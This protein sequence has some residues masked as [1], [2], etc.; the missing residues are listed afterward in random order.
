M[1]MLDRLTEVFTA[2]QRLATTEVELSRAN[3]TVDFMQE[4][5][6]DL[7]RSLDDRGWQAITTGQQ[8]EFSPAGHQ[9]MVEICRTMTV[10]NPLVK[11]GV[12]LRTGYVWGKGVE[13]SAR[14]DDVNQLLQQFIEDN[15]A[16]LFDSQAH[17][18]NEK[19][20]ATDGELFLAFFTDPL[21]GRVRARGIDACEISDVITNH[22]D[23]D[24][25]W[26]YLRRYNEVVTQHVYGD[27]TSYEE[28]RQSTVVAYPALGYRPRQ[29][30]QR[31]GDPSRGDQGGIPIMWD[32][33][34]L[35]VPVNRLNGWLRGVPDVYAAIAFAR[36]YREFL[37]DWALVMKS[38]SK[39][40]WR[41]VG[42]TKTRA[43][44]A[45]QK[46]T[47]NATVPPVGLPNPAAGQAAAMG[48]GQALEAIPKSGATID[49]DSGRPLAAMV[50]AALGVPVTMLLTDP[51]VTGARATAET[52]DQPTQL[53]TGMRRM[54]WSSVFKRIL[55]YVVD[56]AVVAP[57]G[58]LQGTLSRDEW[59]QL[60]VELAD[61]KDR[62]VEVVWPDMTETPI[63]LA[64]AAIVD[65]AGLGL[66]PDV[67]VVKLLLHALGVRDVD[68]I[69]EANTDAEGNWVAKTTTAKTNAGQAAVDAARRGEDPAEAWR[70]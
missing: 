57:R 21:T 59:D 3:E 39:F 12:A 34:M 24:E 9:S 26:Y 47:A 62:T 40:T 70:A 69:V 20:L 35:H 68:E 11:R 37:G 31:L 28:T 5:I 66:I 38:L 17:E 15:Q 10:A 61:E 18:E 56:A 6:A 2:P 58:P 22:D 63:D 1:G 44:K 7:E 64:V 51:G 45:A 25:P 48:P 46:V 54:L 14:D 29:R 53:E 50:A 42:D 16:V 36:A 4:S 67:E 33:P 27:G 43:Q 13:I 55:T 65:A 19:G 52:L 8:L 41:L 60:V 49:A 32:A 23:R 30:R